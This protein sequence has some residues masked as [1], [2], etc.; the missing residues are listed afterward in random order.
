MLTVRCE[1]CLKILFPKIS[2]S[3]RLRYVEGIQWLL[4]CDMHIFEV[5][6]CIV[7]Q[8]DSCSIL[9]WMFGRLNETFTWKIVFDCI[10]VMY[11]C[12]GIL[13]VV[14]YGKASS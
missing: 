14:I 10:D 3:L 1:K 12:M 7:K 11:T 5:G 6:C 8:Q 4:F 9:L 13:I 2:T